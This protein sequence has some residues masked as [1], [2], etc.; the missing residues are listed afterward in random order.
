MAPRSLLAEMNAILATDFER[1]GGM[2][3]DD[4]RF[5]GMLSAQP[6]VGRDHVVGVFRMLVEICDDV[7][8]VEEFA[9]AD[10]LVLLSRGS[11]RGRDY[12]ALQVLRFSGDGRIREFHDSL[13]P[14]AALEAL[15]EA[16]AT[17]V[18]RQRA[19]APEPAG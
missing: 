12:E 16:A 11:I 13:R 15:R 8:Y 3:A 9:S 6:A 19:I 1:L 18:A 5:Y 7:R 10:G 2:L 14:L 17:W 4:V